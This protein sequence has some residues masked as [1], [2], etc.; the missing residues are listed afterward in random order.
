MERIS[1]N[2]DM[3]RVIGGVIHTHAGWQVRVFGPSD[4]IDRPSECLYIRTVPP[5][6]FIDRL[7]HYRQDM[8]FSQFCLMAV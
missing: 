4:L 5:Y 7:L 2:G 1:Y 3:K 8:Q 6:G